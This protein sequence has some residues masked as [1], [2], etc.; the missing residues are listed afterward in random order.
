[1][2]D[3]T[4]IEKLAHINFDD[5][6][7]M[8][9]YLN[10]DPHI[11]PTKKELRP[12]IHSL[13]NEA[14]D[15]LE[16]LEEDGHLSHD[17][18]KSLRR[19]LSLID[20]FLE[21]DL[22]RNHAKGL[23]IFTCSSKNYWHVEVTPQPVK[24]DVFINKAPHVRNL[25]RVFDE[26]RHFGLLMI[27]RDKARLFRIY[28]QEILEESA[29]LDEVPGQHDRGQWSQKRFEKHIEDH[30]DRHIKH[31]MEALW[32][33]FENNPFNYLFVSTTEGLLPLLLKRMHPYIKEL[34]IGNVPM[35]MY[36]S[37][38]QV[39][40]EVTKLQHQIEAEEQ[41][42]ELDKVIRNKM[43]GEHA[44]W[45]I[46]GVLSAVSSNNVVELLVKRD[47]T[48]EGAKCSNCGLLT[49]ADTSC[50][51]CAHHLEH[52]DD[53]VEEIVEKANHNNAEVIFVDSVEMDY[54]LEK[55]AAIT[56][57]ER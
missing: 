10:I 24:N 54:Q 3:R 9:F 2:L 15:K 50:P 44:A 49:L 36:A 56:R 23:A 43:M 38:T 14:R 17:Q 20:D 21:Y 52:V 47:F 34:Y 57:G 42:R 31:T 26:F 40:G 27:S 4:K 37:D 33:Y 41:R 53:V 51:A 12:R 7:I 16:E 35:E 19:D 13:I 30:V 5:S 6:L 32:N 11:A 39:L 45:G 25:L 18:K 8:S 29:V 1:M 28:G 55:I 48:H 46:A 22:K